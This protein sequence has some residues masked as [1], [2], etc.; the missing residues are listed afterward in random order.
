[1]VEVSLASALSASSRLISAL[2]ILTF[3]SLLLNF[4]L[5]L[6]VLLVSPG[7]SMIDELDLQLSLNSEVRSDSR[8]LRVDIAIILSK[9]ISSEGFFGELLRV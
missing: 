9:L 2:V 7:F 5:E 6:E 4:K 1:M 3:S 8:F